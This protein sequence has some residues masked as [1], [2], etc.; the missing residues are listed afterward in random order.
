MNYE[1]KPPVEQTDGNYL[2]VSYSHKFSNTVYEDIWFFHDQGIRYWYDFGI[3]PGENWQKIVAPKLKNSAV[4]LVYIDDTF[5]FSDSIEK[6]VRFIKENNIPFIPVFKEGTYR[7]AKGKAYCTDIDIP[8]SREDLFDEMFKLSSGIVFDNENSY[9]SQL[10]D[11]LSKYGVASDDISVKKAKKVSNICV[12]AK[13]SLFSRAI[14]EGLQSGF[15]KSADYSV[16]YKFIKNG[17]DYAAKIEFYNL[18]R[19]SKDDYDIF[20]I[21]PLDEVDD[22]LFDIISDLSTDKKIVLL[23]IDLSSEQRKNIKGRPPIFVCS[24]FKEGG[25]SL[26]NAIYSAFFK[27]NTS[28]TY[29][30]LCTGPNKKSAQER[31][32]S[33]KSNLYEYGISDRVHELKLDSFDHEAA[34]RQIEDHFTQLFSQTSCYE[35]LLLFAG[36]DTI[37]KYLMKIYYGFK[38]SRLKEY[39]HKFKWMTLFGYDGVKNITGESV[40]ADGGMNYCTIDVA[41][42]RQGEAVASIIMERFCSETEVRVK[43]IVD[44]R[45]NI[46]PVVVKSLSPLVNYIRHKKV[47]IFDLDGTIADTETLHWQAYNIL[48]KKY[49]VEL[50]HEDIKRYI[51]NSELS[52]YKMIENDYGITLNKKDFLSER[53]KVYLDLVKSTR[54][55]P[56]CWVREFAQTFKGARTV[57]LTSQVPEIVEYLMSYWK[58]DDIVP[59]QYR[60]SAH[61]GKLTKKEIF[62]NI[63]EYVG[64]KSITAEDVIVFEDS[65]HVVELAKSFGYDVVGIRHGF[66]TDKLSECDFIIDENY[67]RG[68]FIGLSGLDVV[69]RDVKC[70]PQ[71]NMKTKS[72][73]FYLDIGG[74]AAKAALT[75]ASMGGNATLITHLGQSSIAINMKEILKQKG[76]N[77]IDIAEVGES[78][79][80]ISCIMVSTEKATRT[81]VSGQHEV[82]SL[83]V[84][85]SLKLSEFNF[86]LYDCNFPKL[87]DRIVNKLRDSGIELVLDCG[88]WKNNIEKALD[89]AKVAIASATFSDYCD[90]DINCLR[91]K[92]MIPFT[93]KTCGENSI[94]YDEGDGLKEIEVAPLHGVNTLGAGDMFHG[95][96][97]YYY[98]NKKQQFSQALKSSRDEVYR[99]LK[100]RK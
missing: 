90:N 98:Y 74:P 24:D 20:I 22:E 92:Y 40:L 46:R 83:N 87:T 82:N 55:E 61:D 31:C 8:E 28:N 17:Y 18:L 53:L 6:E 84:L 64:D 91:D 76:V 48:L 52:I 14:K 70:L 32:E 11:K 39:L 96:F 47:Y 43:P 59:K 67:C 7:S 73:D 68:L 10:S 80:N 85:N 93:A 23:D 86:A 100:S 58:I 49:G 37:A 2:F 94:I 9:H 77:V 5:F 36:N 79:P 54:L 57:L 78:C 66:N 88:N 60:Y 45:I 15:E 27:L 65:A 71:E 63:S 3:E 51:G 89:Y 69:Y 1:N 16:N 56:Y 50:K 29:L 99:L 26:A 34:A 13:D 21:R 41:P 62:E 72:S 38:D 25:K 81:I 33:L 44:T 30:L 4:A 75:Y 42:K 19:N 97:C 12:L 35:N 95:A